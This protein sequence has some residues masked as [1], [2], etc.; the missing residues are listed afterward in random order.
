MT[1]GVPLNTE[2]NGIPFSILMSQA[3]KLK[4]A[5]A[6]PSRSKFDSFPSFYQHSI[7]P[8][9]KV[10]LARKKD[11]HERMIDAIGFKNKGNKAFKRGDFE[12][13]ITHHEMAIAVFKYLKNTNPEWQ[14]EVRRES[15]LYYIMK[16]NLIFL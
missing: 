4:T 1:T 7:Y 16:S 11:F 9:E 12:D 14:T 5:Q 10:L 8:Q 2:V 6:A 15:E 3:A 13:A